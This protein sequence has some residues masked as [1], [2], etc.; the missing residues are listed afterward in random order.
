MFITEDLKNSTGS[1]N[2]HRFSFEI[3]KRPGNRRA[4]FGVVKKESRWC[5]GGMGI[6]TTAC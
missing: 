4:L 3:F 2:F 5:T 6:H 1:Q